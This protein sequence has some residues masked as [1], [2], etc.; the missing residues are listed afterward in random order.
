MWP[1]IP[2]DISPALYFT[3]VG[4]A[5]LITGVS[6]SG[7]GGSTFIAA[8][9]LMA[10]VMPTRHMLGI[11]LPM[12]IAADVLSNLHFIRAWNWRFLRPMLAGALVGIVIGTAVLFSLQQTA[13]AT[14]DT[15]L[16]ILIGSICLLFVV[17]Q[18]YTLTGRKVPTLPAGRGS[19][20]GVGVTCGVVST[21]SHTAGP[22]ATLYLLHARL[23][24]RILVGSLLLFFIIVNV[25]KVPTY[26]YLGI[27]NGSTLRDSIWFIPL[28]PVGTLAGAWMHKHLKETPFLIIMYTATAATAGHM[29]FRA[30]R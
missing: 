7:F 6:K 17:V 10:T 28:L 4:L 25:A 30:L 12:L 26:V 14:I 21:L 11:M 1:T 18:V 20:L 2:P 24:K 22:I 13:Q 3:C 15:V 29:V 8:V 9:P 19:S 27:I 16:S 5:V 23:E